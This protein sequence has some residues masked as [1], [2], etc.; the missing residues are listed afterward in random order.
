MKIRGVLNSHIFT[1]LK[2]NLMKSMR[3]N[4]LLFLL[5][6]FTT[7]FTSCGDKGDDAPAGPKQN[8]V[9]YLTADGGYTVM[10]AALEKTGWKTKLNASGSYTLLAVSDAQLL[11][12][13]V[14][15]ASM[16][17]AEAEILV[18]YHVLNKS[19]QE[20]EFPDKQYLATESKGGP[21][22]ENL[23]LYVEVANPAVRFNGITI[24]TSVKATNG[25]VYTMAG[26]LKPLTV[27]EALAIN[28]NIKSYK[29]MVNMEAPVKTQL[30]KSPNT[31]FAT[32]ETQ[33]I[34]Y[35]NDNN[36]TVTSINPS[37]R[38]KILNNSII[39]NANKTPDQLGATEKTMGADLTVKSSAGNILLNN[40]ASFEAPNGQC[41]DGVIHVINHLLN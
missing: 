30:G 21:D 22:G 33:M 39:P 13:G 10:L 23:A 25:M 11:S 8:I 3:K 1:V 37:A 35:L 29:V 41:T 28:P 14:D 31:V 9:E 27:I 18:T 26:T 2:N 4:L 34:Q 24:A 36:T 12:D 5:I 15:L 40:K 6:P 20:S 19:Y 38:T 32:S 7:I 16:T 17:E